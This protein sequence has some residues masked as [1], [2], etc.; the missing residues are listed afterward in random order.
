MRA[1]WTTMATRNSSANE[2]LLSVINSEKGARVIKEVPRKHEKGQ[3]VLCV[4]SNL[5][6]R[7]H[8]HTHTQKNRLI[9]TCKRELCRL[10]L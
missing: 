5:S 7:T 1:P 3:E 8:T 9:S 4:P 6:A 10:V 2:L